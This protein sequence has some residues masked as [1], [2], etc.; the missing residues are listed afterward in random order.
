[1]LRECGHKTKCKAS[2]YKGQ[3][4][5]IIIV[6]RIPKCSSPFNILKSKITVMG[7]LIYFDF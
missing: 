7:L 1:M 4:I 6:T 2:H 5:I 3:I